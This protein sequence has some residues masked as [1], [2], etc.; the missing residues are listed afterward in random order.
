MPR[1]GTWQRK[2]VMERS[3]ILVVVLEVSSI[4]SSVSIVWKLAVVQVYAT[5]H[6]IESWLR[7]TKGNIWLIRRLEPATILEE[8]VVTLAIETRT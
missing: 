6:W 3:I 8:I 7:R 2:E 5:N 4:I 1:G